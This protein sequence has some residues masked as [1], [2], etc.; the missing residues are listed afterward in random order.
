MGAS[1][2]RT[3]AIAARTAQLVALLALCAAGVCDAAEL[4]APPPAPRVECLRVGEGAVHGEL[5]AIASGVVTLRAEGEEHAYRLDEFREIV[6]EAAPAAGPEPAFTL[7]TDD[8]RRMLVR[9]VRTSGEEAIDVVGPGWRAGGIRLASL[10]ALALRDWRLRADEA[11]LRA[12]AEARSSRP[13]GNDLLYVVRGERRQAVACIV[14]RIT[15]DG[16]AIVAA[17]RRL[18][19]P[20]AQVGWLVL[21]Q[22]AGLQLREER[23]HRIELTDGTTLR[24]VSVS[25]AEG[26]LTAERGPE[27]YSIRLARL[28]RIRVASEAYVYLSD[29]EPAQVEVE[30][31]L[32]VAWPPRFDRA[33]TGGPLTLGGRTYAKGIGAHTRTRITYSLPGGYGRLLGLCGVDDA[34]G[35]L[36]RVTFRVLLDGQPAFEA[37]PLSGGTAP[38][39]VRVELAGAQQLTL[40]TDFGSPVDASGNLA[41]WA[42]ARLVR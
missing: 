36:G 40:V 38:V 17:G 1:R 18:A 27:R 41:D 6:V 42:E 28:A 5:V 29:L 39:P 21:S 32:D 25:L 23:A 3:A 34:A 19:V 35:T 16:P 8:G 24:A 12:F 13:V 10:S 2:R 7:W 31:F 30:P 37:G 9:Q 14:D 4:S 33:V 15:E 26:M 22:A 11:E 20:W